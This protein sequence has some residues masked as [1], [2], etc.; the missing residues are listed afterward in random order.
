MA[1][2]SKA[3]REV[4]DV[5][6]NLFSMGYSEEEV[7]KE[8]DYEDADLVGEAWVRLKKNGENEMRLA[9]ELIRIAHLIM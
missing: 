1:R 9:S 6:R 7:L 4:M 8:L 3:V 2:E 5:I